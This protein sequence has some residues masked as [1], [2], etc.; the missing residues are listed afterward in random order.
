MSDLKVDANS[1]N[2]LTRTARYHQFMPN[3]FQ[4]LP[5]LTV[6]DADVLLLTVYAG[7][8]IYVTPVDD[9]LFSAHQ[10][11]QILDPNNANNR[12]WYKSDSPLSILGCTEQVCT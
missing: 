3:A 8:I 12:T 6:P 1:T 4:P 7:G 10:P 5:E 11:R 2:I 9:P